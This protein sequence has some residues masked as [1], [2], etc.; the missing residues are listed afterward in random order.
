MAVFQDITAIR[1]L[2]RVREEFLASVAHDL[3]T[4]L[5]GIRG[6]AQLARRRLARLDAPEVARVVEHLAQI[7]QGVS[8]LLDLTNELVDVTRAQLG[9]APPLDRQ[10]V[11]L[12]ALVH[13]VIAQ[14]EGLT[15][16]GLRV[17][18]GLPTLMAP[19]DAT[20][21]ERVIGNLLSNATKYSPHGG[22]I[23]VQVARQEGPAGPLALIAVR[24]PGIG[25]PAADLPHIFERFWRAR[26]VE[27]HIPGTGIGLASA[28]Q[29][30]A[31]H[32]GTISVESQE[33][34]GSTFTVRL[35]LTPAP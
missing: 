15:E 1:D 31:E 11:D 7:D 23:V 26:N 16:H 25:I 12:I 22:D 4:P 13:G 32:G 14:H 3:K 30:V 2:E 35:P 9:H 17:E 28:L 6:H 19:A 18:T 33:G 21:I 20:R 27:N 8:R 29:I 34:Q 10:T 24:D 5:T